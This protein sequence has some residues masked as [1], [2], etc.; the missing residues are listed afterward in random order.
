MAPEVRVS[1]AEVPASFKSNESAKY[2][3]NEAM[4]AVDA[5]R[6][7]IAEGE[8][9][10]INVQPKNDAQPADI[11][12]GK[13]G[14]VN[15]AKGINDGD[16]PLSEYNVQVEAGADPKVTEKVIDDLGSMIHEKC[17]NCTPRINSGKDTNGSDLVSGDY[18]DRFQERYKPADDQPEDDLPDDPELP[19]G[20][21]GGGGG[22]GGCDVQPPD[23]ELS[24]EED[25]PVDPGA[26]NGAS[27]E[28]GFQALK[29]MSTAMGD[30]HANHYS[31]WMMASM[32]PPELLAE[33]GDPPWSPEKMKKLQEYMKTHGK[34][35]KKNI[36]DRAAAL[37]KA[38]DTEGAK[39]LND[40]GTNMESICNDPAK[41]EQFSGALANFY[42]K[43]AH[44][45]ANTT[46]VHA[47]FGN[48]AKLEA[49]IRNSQLVETAKKY[50][51]SQGG[52]PDL[53]KVR[54][55]NGDKLIAE[56]QRN[57]TPP[58]ETE[59]IKFVDLIN[60]NAKPQAK[61]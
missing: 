10:K 34:D 59:I 9:P 7:K 3:V 39:A 5:A 51:S 50:D 60:N 27:K 18:R 4:P 14:S 21:G 6:P 47:M 55:D 37:E 46:D 53:E 56:L 13:D 20:G 28:R 22:G 49:A 26:D 61:K 32:L 45:E 40:F 16:K 11:V 15:I 41:L 19:D 58:K 25:Q 36:G 57:P 44:G 8:S 23:E 24:P 35:I 17:A 2:Q 42:D 31:N 52:A 30:M 48:D 43:A 29:E 12:I 1:T 38:G 54:K 33:L